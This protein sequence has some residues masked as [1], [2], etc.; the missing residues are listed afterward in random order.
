MACISKEVCVTDDKKCHK[1]QKEL[2]ILHSVNNT[3]L[4]QEPPTPRPTTQGVISAVRWA[5]VLWQVYMVTIIWAALAVRLRNQISAAAAD[6][7]SAAQVSVVDQDN[8][9]AAV[10]RHLDILKADL[11]WVDLDLEDLED[12]EDQVDLDS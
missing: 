4:V 12:R 1:F 5:R 9:E 11:Q 6:T 2:S 7:A 8:S 3:V 10:D